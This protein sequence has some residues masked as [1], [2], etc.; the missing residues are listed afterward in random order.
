MVKFIKP[1]GRYGVNDSAVFSP[2]FEARL[3]QEGFAVSADTKKTDA[4]TKRPEPVGPQGRQ[5][6]VSR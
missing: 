5:T 2:E 1:Q 3:I 4:Q 6:T